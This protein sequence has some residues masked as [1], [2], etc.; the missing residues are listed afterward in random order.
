MPDGTISTSVVPY[1]PHEGDI[2]LFDD[3]SSTWRFLYKM[4]GSDVPDHSGMV[5]KLPDG[6]LAL[7]ESGPDDF[8]L[9]GPYVRLLEAIPRLQCYQ[10]SMYVRRLKQPL[11]TEQSRAL[12][13]FAM[14]QEGK[15][16][17]IGRLLLQATPCRC[18][19]GW[20]AKLFAH[21][22]TDRC[23]WLCSELVVA[24]GTVAGLFD[25]NVHHANRMYPLDMMEDKAFDL[26]ATWERPALWLPSPITNPVVGD[27]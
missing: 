27:R 26:S 15:R 17:A 21:T 2:I 11:S 4:V 18:R 23:S 3:H 6:S 1:Q 13:H 10:G 16:Y 25:P 8:K 22:Y 24:A 20:R 12:T 14:E 7:L 5:V 19:S 9:A